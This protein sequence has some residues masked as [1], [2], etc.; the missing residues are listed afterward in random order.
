[1]TQLEEGLLAKEESVDEQIVRERNKEMARLADDLGALQEMMHDMHQ[2]TGD[3]GLKLD[4]A[5]DHVKT[6]DAEVAEGTRQTK[7]SEK[8]AG[9]LRCKIAIVVIVVAAI[10][11]ILVT[12][13]VLALRPKKT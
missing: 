1:M 13:L 2:L 5:H 12:I 3:Q 6:A 4:E 11:G 7:E 9:K 8:L 10:V